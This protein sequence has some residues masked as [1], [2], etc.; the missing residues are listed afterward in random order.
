MLTLT[1]PSI[2]C[3]LSR[4]IECNQFMGSSNVTLIL[5]TKYTTMSALNAPAKM[6]N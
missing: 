5:D 1:S 3:V 6:I 4:Q 2:N